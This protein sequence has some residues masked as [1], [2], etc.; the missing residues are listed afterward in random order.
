MDFSDDLA[1]AVRKSWSEPSDP[2]L[3]SESSNS[4]IGTP[5]EGSA[6]SSGTHESSNPDSSEEY[7]LWKHHYAISDDAKTTNPQGE[8]MNVLQELEF[9]EQPRPQQ[10]RRSSIED[11]SKIR[12]WLNPR[13]SFSG[14]PT[15]ELNWQNSA[16]NRCWISILSDERDMGPIRVLDFTL[17]ACHSRYTLYVLV[18]HDLEDLAKE[19]AKLGIHVIAMEKIAPRLVPKLVPDSTSSPSDA[20]FFGNWNLLAP[21]LCLRDSFELV[22]YLSPRCA[23]LANVDELLASETVSDEIDNETCVLLTNTTDE[24]P[25]MIVLRPN[26]GIEACIREYMSI[27]IS[28]D[29]NEKWSRLQNSTG[30]DVLKELFK[31]SWGVVAGEYCQRGPGTLSSGIKIVENP[32]NEPWSSQSSDE[33]TSIWRRAWLELN[34]SS[35]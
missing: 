21:F 12:Q 5:Q 19:L 17:R 31:D 15:N 11:V 25:M 8:L 32:N 9:S 2:P 34:R 3:F 16:Q 22:C 27:Y 24:P 26:D 1:S 29:S 23:V 28:K 18:P 14:A 4:P 6:C 20:P 10:V 7:H 30:L 13:S 33:I 35:P